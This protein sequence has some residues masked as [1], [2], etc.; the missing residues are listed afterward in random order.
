MG[1]ILGKITHMLDATDQMLLSAL[2]KDAHLTAQQLGDLL[3]L[4]PAKQDDADNGLR[5]KAISKAMP[6]D[7]TQTSWG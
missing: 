2:Q 6:H 4:S 5:L 7:W 1:V 3:N